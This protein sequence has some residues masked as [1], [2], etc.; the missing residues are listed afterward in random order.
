MVEPFKNLLD[1]LLDLEIVEPTEKLIAEDRA[2]TAISEDVSHIAK[3]NSGNNFTEG[4]PRKTVADQL[5]PALNSSDRPQ[6]K[7]TLPANPAYLRQQITVLEQKLASSENQMEELTELVNSLIPLIA[8]LLRLKSN[9]LRESIFETIVPIIDEIITQ[10]S[11][12]DRQRMGAALANILPVA[13]AGAIE[14]QPQSIAKAIAPEVALA[15]QEQIRLDRDSI[16][17]TLGPE[18]GHAIKTQIELER[19]AM[20]DALYP[21]IGSTISKYMV[22]VVKTINEKV[23]STLSPEGIK[24]K[25]RAKIQGVSEAELILQESIKYQVRAIF[26]IHKASGLVIREVQPDSQYQLESD[27]VAGMLTAI[28]SFANECIASSSELDEID[29][30]DSKIILEV[31]GYCYIAVVVKGEPPKKFIRKIRNTLGQIVIKYGRIME[32]YDGDPTTIPEPV[33]LLLEKLIEPDDRQQEQSKKPTALLWL[34]A[35]L[36][37]MV[38][39]PW[40]IVQ[41]RSN[42]GSR[43]EQETAIALD[44][45]PELSVYRLIPEVRRGKLILTGRVPSEYL[46]QLAT[47]V[48]ATI[49]ERKNLEVNNQILAVNVPPD[50]SLTAQEIK[51]VT[52]LLNQQEGVAITSQYQTKTVTVEGFILDRQATQFFIAAFE[53]IPGVD[54]VVFA[55]EK[56]LPQL[57]TRI[58]F[59]PN[60]TA[61]KS[62]DISSKIKSIHEFLEQYPQLNLQLV[63]YSDRSGSQQ[64]NLE[65]GRERARAVREALIS[66]GVSPARLQITASAELPPDVTPSQPLWLSRC[67]RF[68]PFISSSD[69]YLK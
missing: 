56:Q 14:T 7:E 44:A 8:E 3:P 49:A 68:E 37:G 53:Q 21:V 39:V 59:E 5:Q 67:V 20:V 64:Q 51:R 24:R 30:G 27:L 48:A 26:L 63:G 42:V 18:M 19:D 66:L 11:A 15:I 54:T 34:L 60:S 50:P 69:N 38:V 46:R 25:I 1:L 65:L 2:K 52:S 22:E 43:I 36:L 12:Q 9:E 55:V 29:Y 28:R 58:Y 61:L 45:A 6:A 41:Y 33:Q 40:G 16:S 4:I 17:Q 31:A 57:T 13:I 47:A 35:M 62:A 23:E 32:A 10:R